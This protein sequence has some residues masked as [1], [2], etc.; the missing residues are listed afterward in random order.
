M[1]FL[2]LFV[3]QK[4]VFV[5]NMNELCMKTNRCKAHGNKARFV[6][7]GTGLV[8]H[9]DDSREVILVEVKFQFTYER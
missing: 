1:Y 8:C 7:L 3:G 5:H 4:F 2:D 6:E 9:T